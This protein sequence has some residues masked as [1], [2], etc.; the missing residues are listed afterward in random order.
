MKTVVANG[1]L[2]KAASAGEIVAELKII[3]KYIESFKV[4]LINFEQSSSEA[5]C[6]FWINLE[7]NETNLAAEELLTNSKLPARDELLFGI[8]TRIIWF[9]ECFD[10][11]REDDFYVL[12]NSSGRRFREILEYALYGLESQGDWK[13]ISPHILTDQ[14]KEVNLENLMS[15]GYLS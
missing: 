3:L 7:N 15:D 11:Y 4:D 10:R 5:E 2:Y 13:D 8:T 12:R 6:D 14:Y 9:T 1:R